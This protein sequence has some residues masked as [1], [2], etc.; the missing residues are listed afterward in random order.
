MSDSQKILVIDDSEDHILFTSQILEDNGFQYTVARNGSEALEALQKERPALMLL[1]ILMPKK[2]GLNVLMKMREDADLSSIPVI[3]V[4][5]SDGI[6]GIDMT[7]GQQ[8][9]PK[10]YGDD[11]A[12]SF[13]EFIRDKLEELKPDAYI[14]KPVDPSNLVA[15][16]NE[17]LH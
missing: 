4:S 12:R 3:I 10:S 6:T 16:I 13:G 17:L 2:G 9:A 15:K 8:Q 7:T 11:M 5:G 1:D 14:A